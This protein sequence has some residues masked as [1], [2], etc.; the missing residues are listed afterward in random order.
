MNTPIRATQDQLRRSVYA[1]LIVLTTGAMLGRILAVDSVDSSRLQQYLL[2]RIP[3]E[4]ARREKDFSERGFT[5]KQIASKLKR[6]EAELQDH[7]QLGRPFLS[8]NDRSRWCT[9]RALVEP[10]M[11]VPGV[12]YAIDNVIQQN[13]WDTIDMVKHDGHLY[14]SKPPLFPTLMA[15]EYWLIYRITGA[16]L[17]TH[18]YA[19]GRFML[20]TINVVPLIILFLILASLI[21]RFGTGDWSRIFVMGAATFG[22]FL[23]T[24]AVTINN[25]LPAAVSV[26][27]ALWA[28]VRI[29]FDDDRRLR[30]FALVGLA[31]AFAAAN[32][33]P[34]LSLLVVLGLFL[35]WKAP[36]QT[37]IA[38]VPAAAVIIAAFFG[39]N[40]IAHHDLRP[41]YAHR[42]SQENWYDYTYERN[43]RTVESYWRHRVGIDRGESSQATY[44]LHV[45]VGH[46]GIFSLTPVWILSFLGLA[47]WLVNP[48]DRRLRYLALGIAALSLVC[49]AFYLTRPQGDRNYGGM[50]SGLRWMFWFAP[51]WL[52]GMLPV[53][54]WLA[55]RRWGRATAYVLLTLSV[56][57]ASY[58]TWNPW[59]QPWLVHWL[60]TLGWVGT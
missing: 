19:I 28:G 5:A 53:T 15:G 48:G 11:R 50:T 39:T 16:T 55:S 22:T 3:D 29:W 45:L 14:S 12:P 37:L 18:P 41:A 51:L 21:E 43:G 30:W 58:P 7:A 49:L 42:D 31:A 54:D 13:G 57:S 44:A 46:H 20:V 34:A 32:E 2:N 33:L 59:V 35:L 26:A 25:H 23:T 6:L 8:A 47:M 9:V 52:V 36:R 1:L 38:F 40:W 10:D 24:F 56:L 4:L 27:I 60:Q 17:E